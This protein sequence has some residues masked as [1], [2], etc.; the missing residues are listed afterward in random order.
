MPKAHLQVSWGQ[1]NRQS[2][3][4][5][6]RSRFNRTSS[7]TSDKDHSCVPMSFT[8]QKKEYRDLQTFPMNCLMCITRNSE[9]LFQLRLFSSPLFIGIF[10]F[11][12]ILGV[13]ETHPVQM[14]CTE[15][16]FQEG[17]D[18]EQVFLLILARNIKHPPNPTSTFCWPSGS[19]HQ[20][21]FFL[22]GYCENLCQWQRSCVKREVGPSA[23]FS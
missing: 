15:E 21:S 12:G 23:H 20:S 18:K 10:T 5:E 13:S 17:R 4:L 9:R 8:P 1:T 16:G 6:L 2:E 14:W 7:I 11:D 19:R 22:P 3:C